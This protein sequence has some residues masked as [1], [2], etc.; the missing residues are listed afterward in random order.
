[1]TRFFLIALMITS[2]NIASAES[3]GAP[4]KNRK[5]R[6]GGQ[7]IEPKDLKRQA[8]KE[9]LKEAKPGVPRANIGDAKGGTSIGPIE[10]AS[11]PRHETKGKTLGALNGGSGRF[12]SPDTSFAALEKETRLA[13]KDP[14]VA[15]RVVENLKRMDSELEG[16]PQARRGLRVREEMFR[17]ALGGKGEVTD[18]ASRRF[19]VALAERLGG[20]RTKEDVETMKASVCP[21]NCGHEG[22]RR[23]CRRLGRLLQAAGQLAPAAFATA[24]AAFMTTDAEGKD[25]VTCSTGLKE[26]PFIV[27]KGL[28]TPVPEEEVTTVRE[29]TGK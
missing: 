20:K 4:Q 11:K 29:T 15:N 2:F 21:A 9:L 24:F 22:G 5:E 3:R 17:E 14:L 18:E 12:K 23:T 28:N 26:L 25:S 6:K 10:E 16:D 7:F 8:E 27:V 19:E 13:L 1:M